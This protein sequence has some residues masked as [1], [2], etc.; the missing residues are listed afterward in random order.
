MFCRVNVSRNAGPE[1]G[2]TKMDK[3]EEELFKVALLALPPRTHLPST[4]V[5]QLKVVADGKEHAW[6]LSVD[7]EFIRAY[8]KTLQDENEQ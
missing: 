3:V 2:E 6:Q 5:A 8:L 1:Q 7:E 4:L